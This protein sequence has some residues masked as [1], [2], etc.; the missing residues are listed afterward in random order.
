[1]PST[2][3]VSGGAGVCA[4]RKHTINR[5]SIKCLVARAS[6][7]LPAALSCGQ[8]C[9]QI[10]R[11]NSQGLCRVV[12]L[13]SSQA[14]SHQY[15]ESIVYPLGT[16]VTRSWE[17]TNGQ[18]VRIARDTPPRTADLDRI[19]MVVSFKYPPSGTN[20]VTDLRCWAA[21]QKVRKVEKN[22]MLYAGV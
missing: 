13:P 2:S 12:S 5:C 11:A 7:A 20:L 18:I 21:N 19:G 15:E 16:S 1:M 9:I 4:H 17:G 6:V 22:C 10:S 3:F 14:W 8:R